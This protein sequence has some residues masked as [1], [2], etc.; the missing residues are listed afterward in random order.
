VAVDVIGAGRV[1]HPWMSSHVWPQTGEVTNARIPGRSGRS[2]LPSVYTAAPRQ[3]CVDAC[4]RIWKGGSDTQCAK[5]VQ[6]AR[7]ACDHVEPPGPREGGG[8]AERQAR[9]RWDGWYDTGIV[10]RWVVRWKGERET[11]RVQERNRPTG[12]SRGWPNQIADVSPHSA[13]WLRDLYGVRCTGARTVERV[14]A[15]TLTY[16]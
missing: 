9:D 11:G 13:R 1:R 15:F 7:R 6:E 14:G 2:R 12:H 3:A 16:Q 5:K 4:V 10:S 8:G